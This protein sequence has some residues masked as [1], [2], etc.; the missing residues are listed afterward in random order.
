VVHPVASREIVLIEAHVSG[1]EHIPVNSALVVSLA[2]AFPSWTIHVVAEESHRAQLMARVGAHNVTSS[3]VHVPPRHAP[4]WTRIRLDFRNIRFCMR[5]ARATGGA[6]I[7]ILSGTASII[8]AIK[9]LAWVRLPGR[10]KQT[11]ICFLHSVLAEIRGWRSRNPYR[12][13]TDI[14]SA[15]VCLGNGNLKYCVLEQSIKQV[16]E[17]FLPNVSRHIHVFPHP[18]SEDEICREPKRTP[19]VPFRFA[20]IGRATKEKGFRAFIEAAEEINQRYPGLAE[21]HA[22]G[23]VASD[24]PHLNLD[25]LKTKPQHARIHRGAYLELI[26]SIDFAVIPLGREYELT[27]SGSLLDA[28]AA[29]RPL[30]ISDSLLARNLSREFG[31]IGETFRDGELFRAIEQILL[32]FDLE[33]YGRFIRNLQDF[34]VSRTPRFLSEYLRRI[35]ECPP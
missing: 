26:R 14:R 25:V 4:F 6:P 13:A 17:Q 20:F 34:G 21:F 30:L 29:A 5:R 11:F 35:L 31:D 12:R 7:V 2:Q 18:I 19:H 15:L 27:A 8:L 33:S 24:L 22:I 1:Q 9:L 3:L 28:V 10:R 16:V 32:N 23:R